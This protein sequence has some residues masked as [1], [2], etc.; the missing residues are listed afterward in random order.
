MSGAR[1]LP[2]RA[3]GVLGAAEPSGG[4]ARLAGGPKRSLIKDA[5]AAAVAPGP[6]LSRARAL[7]RSVM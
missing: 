5:D 3:G 4:R 2:L 1:L 6:I 7:R